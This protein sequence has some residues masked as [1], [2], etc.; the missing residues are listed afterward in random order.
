[1]TGTFARGLAAGAAGSVALNAVSYLDMA[2]RGRPASTVPEQVVDALAAR[3]EWEI[4]GRGAV[5]DARRT[6][7]GALAGTANGLGVGVLAS[8]V[9]SLGVRLPAP[10]GAVL[11]GAASA[12][13]TDGA[14]AALGVGDPRTW[15]AGAWLTDAVP[16][17]AYG[18]GVQT[19]LGAVPTP[20][21][22]AVVPAR[23]GLVLR[24][25][26]LGLATG[27]RSALGFAAP[28]VT[29][30]TAAGAP[31]RVST[32]RK[33]FSVAGV[34]VEMLADKQPGMPPRTDGA[35][36]VAR[37]LAAAEG[38]GRLA[39][40]DR[41]NGA[42]PVTVGVAGALA[43]SYAGLGWRRWA[44]GRLPDTAAALIEDGVA[45]ALAALACLPGRNR[46]HLTVIPHT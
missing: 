30:P 41:A 43:G 46:R 27:S 7:L 38:G 15:S 45:L 22:R 18:V 39:A 13:A 28:I 12:A 14:V 9:R 29:A 33:V 5:R 31:G 40:R 23:A 4:P 2:L 32:K 35:A 44:A 37:L 21:E 10:V 17:L 42:L 6:A 24:S 11:A 3:M 1:M 19:V 25:A 26:V 20:R 34:V 16:H 36:M 8:V